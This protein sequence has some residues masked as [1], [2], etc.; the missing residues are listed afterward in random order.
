MYYLTAIEKFGS[1]VETQK[2]Q[3]IQEKFTTARTRSFESRGTKVEAEDTEQRARNLY[4]DKNY[5]EAK[6]AAIKAKEL[7]TN[8]GM[9]SKVDDMDVLLEQIVTD[10]QI[11]DS[12][13]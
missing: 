12:L 11:A 7:Y 13:K 10:A 2:V 9:K 1:L 4:A 3:L 8:L 6:A 5:S